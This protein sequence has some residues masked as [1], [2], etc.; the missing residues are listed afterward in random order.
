MAAVLIGL[1]RLLGARFAGS[2]AGE[3]FLVA[4]LVGAGIA[5]YFLLAWIIGG[6]NR[7]DFLELLKRKKPE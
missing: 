5:V 2:T 4:V 7:E 6:M 3:F 1:Q